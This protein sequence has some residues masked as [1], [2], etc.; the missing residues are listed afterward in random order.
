MKT[1]AITRG[2]GIPQIAKI[3][4]QVDSR[5]NLVEIETLKMA[6]NIPFDGLILP[7]GSDISPAWYGQTNIYSTTPDHALDAIQWAL[8]SRA[9]SEGIPVMGICRGMQMLAVRAG[10]SLWQDVEKQVTGRP[11]P[12]QHPLRNV[13]KVLAARIPTKTVNSFHHQAVRSIPYGFESV[14]T[15][16]DGVIEAIY[17][18]GALGVQFHP[19]Y[20]WVDNPKWESLFVWFALDYLC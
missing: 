5:I 2:S 15:S 6:Q 1:I 13:S 8:V 4:K 18:P 20:L 7:G 19:E 3:M 11:H 17:R 10:G 12:R 16:A 14:A 9:L